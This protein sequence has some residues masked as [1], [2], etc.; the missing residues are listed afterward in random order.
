MNIHPVICSDDIVDIMNNG[1]VIIRFKYVSRNQSTP[2]ENLV[3]YHLMEFKGKRVLGV[4]IQGDSKF[5][6][7]KQWGEGDETNAGL[8]GLQ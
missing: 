6:M 1:S 4:H 2:Q 5:S 7:C 8:P 3:S